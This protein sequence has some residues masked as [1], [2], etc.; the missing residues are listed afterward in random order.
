MKTKHLGASTWHTLDTQYVLVINY[1]GESLSPQPVLLDPVLILE[2]TSEA[3]LALQLH[4]GW[5]G[6]KPCTQL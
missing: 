1:A 5:G 3:L 4:L 6:Q 2:A